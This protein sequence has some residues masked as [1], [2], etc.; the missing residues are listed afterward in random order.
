MLNSRE[1]TNPDEMQETLPPCLTALGTVQPGTAWHREFSPSHSGGSLGATYTYLLAD[2]K[3][4][5]AVLIDPVL[6][7]AKRDAELVGELGLNLL[8]ADFAVPA[9]LKCG[10]QDAAT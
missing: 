2:L 3:T 1:F 9:N 8:Y 5:E 7:T 4:K 6:E 10:I